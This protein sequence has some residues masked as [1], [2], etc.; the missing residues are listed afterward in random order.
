MPLLDAPQQKAL[1]VELDETCPTCGVRLFRN[2]CRQCD[3]FFVECGCPWSE[4]AGHRSYER[5]P[6]LRGAYQD[7]HGYETSPEEHGTRGR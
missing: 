3:E 4:H 2:Y 7:P 6:A 5:E 1:L